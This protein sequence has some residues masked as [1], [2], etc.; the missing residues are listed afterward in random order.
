MVVVVWCDVN[1]DNLVLR[2]RTTPK[3]LPVDRKQPDPL[4]ALRVEA[5][6]GDTDSFAV[7]PTDL[8]GRLD[9][10]HDASAG[11][12]GQCHRRTVPPSEDPTWTDNTLTR[13]KLEENYR[14]IGLERSIRDTGPVAFDVISLEAQKRHPDSLGQCDELVV[15]RTRAVPE[16]SNVSIAG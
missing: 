13:S 8:R 7:G 5:N 16:V 1:I 6:P 10:K 12:S 11:R 4:W 14:W 9:R 2:V 15:D 3:P